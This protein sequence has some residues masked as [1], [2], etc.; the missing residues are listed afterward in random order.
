MRRSRA[1]LACLVAILGGLAASVESF[2]QTR[3]IAFGDSITEGNVGDD[4]SRPEA[5]YPP[6]LE[7]L[8]ATGSITATVDN[9]GKGGEKT[10]EGIT[11][12]DQVL[13]DG[14]DVLLLM[15]GT[16]DISQQISLETTIHNLAEMARKAEDRGLSVIHATCI[17]RFPEARRDADNVLNQ[18]LNEA[19]R[20]LA[21]SAGRELADPFEVFGRQPDLFDRLYDPFVEQDPVGHPNP[22]GYDLLAQTFFHLLTDRDDVPP[23]TGILEPPH[24]ARQV[25]PSQGLV[26]DLW[27]FGRGIDPAST[28]LVID[29]SAVS[30]TVQGNARGA[31]LRYTPSQP[32]QGVV[33]VGLRSR[34]TATPVNIVDR[35]V[36]KFIVAGTVIHAGDLDEDGRVD[37]ADLIAFARA[38]GARRNE[39]R[40]RGG[41]DINDDDV[42]DGLDL[43]A[44][45]ANFGRSSV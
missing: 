3:Y 18:R 25:A 23:V 14:G 27:D 31:T 34:D 4:P 37:G 42:V 39:R 13:A 30:T 10:Y 43:A 28:T 22:A 26:F 6:R 19:I 40:Y 9:R 21:G 38:F 36:A 5:G 33:R 20:D 15:E 2:S 12:I 17:P 35:E 11:R 1:P 16:N 29:G 45:A 32:W 44:L 7:A 41:A 24:G 8:L